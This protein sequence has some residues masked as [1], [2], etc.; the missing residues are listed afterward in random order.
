MKGG[1]VEIFVVE[2]KLVLEVIVKKDEGKERILSNKIE[3]NERKLEEMKK[4]K[5][6]GIFGGERIVKMGNRKGWKKKKENKEILK[7]L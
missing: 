4:E 7:K 1:L 2:R 5:G 6:L 3:R